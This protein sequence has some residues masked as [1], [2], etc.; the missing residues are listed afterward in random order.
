MDTNTLAGALL[1]AWNNWPDR[2]ALVFRDRSLTYAQLSDMIENLAGAYQRL[3]IGRGDRIVCSTSNRPEEIAALGAAWACGAVHV[4]VDHQLTA[5]ELSR[6]LELTQAKALIY[7]PAEEASE[8][9]LALEILSKEYPDIHLMT[10]SDEMVPG[11][12]LSL[13]ELIDDKTVWENVALD[14]LDGPSPQDPALIF[15]SSGTT[16]KPKATVG[17]HGNLCQRWQR[18][19]RWLGFGPEDVHLAQMPLSH[20]FGMMMTMA[21]LL[22]GGRLVLINRFSAKAVLEVIAEQ[23]VTVFNGAPAHFKLILNHLDRSRHNVSS[24]R[25]SIGTAAAFPQ[26]LIRSIWDELGVEF[27]SMYG[28]SEG[29]GVATTDRE[30]ILRGSVG[31]PAPGSVA[32]VDSEKRPLPTGAIGEI[33][34]SREVF[35]VRYW[36]ETGHES[37][38][39]ATQQ[40]AA[41]GSK[42]YYSGD[43]GRVDEDGRLYIFGRLKHQIDRG[44]LKVDPVEVEGALLR[45]PEISDAAVIGLPNPILGETVCACV[46]P[47]FAQEPSLE[48]LRTMLSGELA[49]YKLPEELCILDNIPRTSIGK[50]NMEMLRANVMTRLDH[51]HQQR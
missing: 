38:D 19:A 50:V 46:V 33:A 10:V 2:P 8:P 11:D 43:L 42:W 15:I 24:L 14:A 1:G 20:G 4:G 3:G 21:A 31:R 34:F 18:L 32:I 35:P 7:E 39:T 36:G 48:R 23:G 37:L 9:F 17:Y 26:S 25:F 44:G 22:T 13:S 51:I 6:V 30:D 29:V 28:S 47:A 5:P 12:Y 45:C 40:K 27:M 16:G 41:D 49:P